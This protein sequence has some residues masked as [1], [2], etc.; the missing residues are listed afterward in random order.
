MMAMLSMEMAEAL[1]EQWNLATLVIIQT[2][3]LLVC[4]T[5]KSEEMESSLTQT[6]LLMNTVMMATR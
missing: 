3:Y 2:Q 4:V 5:K 1:L 6:L